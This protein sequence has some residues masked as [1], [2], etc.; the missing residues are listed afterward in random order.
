[1]ARD[2]STEPIISHDSSMGFHSIL[3]QKTA[4]KRNMV[5]I[6]E[7]ISLLDDMCLSLGWIA[8]DWNELRHCL[9]HVPAQFNASFRF[10]GSKRLVRGIV[11]QLVVAEEPSVGHLER[12]L[13]MIWLMHGMTIGVTVFQQNWVDG[14]LVD[15]GETELYF[16][17]R[18]GR[19]QYVGGLK[20]I[21]AENLAT[22]LIA[23]N[24][25]LQ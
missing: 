15:A 21:I 13:R 18:Y 5:A 22:A 7:I 1:M 17:N 12:Q 11:K 19:Y 9:R 20:S 10:N 25:N 8:F 24:E 4:L 6:S 2:T 16:L 14:I 23:T 3:T